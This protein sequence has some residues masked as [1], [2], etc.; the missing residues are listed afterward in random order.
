MLA[1]LDWLLTRWLPEPARA[2]RRR[3]TVHPPSLG[4]ATA[5]AG[6]L[7]ALAAV[8]LWIRP[9]DPPRV[10]PTPLSTLPAQI[11]DW[12]ADGLALD[13]QFLGSATFS[14]WVHRR[15]TKGEDRVDL[16]LGS[17]DHLDARINFDSIK[18]AVPD[19]GWEIEP[20]GSVSLA[21]GRAARRFVAT[22]GSERRLVYLW[23]EGLET[24]LEEAGRALFA[25][26][27]GPFHRPRRA[28]LVRLTTTLSQA[29][30]GRVD[31][32]ERLAAFA[33]LIER[34]IP[35]DRAAG[36]PGASGAAR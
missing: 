34:S 13:M 32:E 31:A 3:R 14:E 17:D 36:V 21:S 15:Y 18:T 19:S 8:T 4:L 30:A 22:S 5:L 27:R 16:L 12:Q 20:A 35:T 7:A 2:P 10:S 9:W 24:P 28:L 1:G 29:P 25:L 26:D 23:T 6:A 11:D 33:A